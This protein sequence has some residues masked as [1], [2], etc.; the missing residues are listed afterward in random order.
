M[1][2][3]TGLY[4]SRLEN[5]S[6]CPEGGT[7]PRRQAVPSGC[8]LLDTQS[9]V[10]QPPPTLWDPHHKEGRATIPAA[11]SHSRFMLQPAVSLE[12]SSKLKRVNHGTG[13][14]WRRGWP[15]GREVF[16]PE[17]TDAQ[18]GNHKTGIWMKLETIILSKLTQ[19]ERTKP[20]MFSL[21]SCLWMPADCIMLASYAGTSEKPQGRE[22]KESTLE[23]RHCQPKHC[24]IQIS[25]NSVG[26]QWG[27]GT[28][29]ST[30]LPHGILMHVI[31]GQFSATH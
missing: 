29:V 28:C 1:C 19:E 31:N 6:Q 4:S 23:L 5:P 30:S 7:E 20:H 25:N 3:Q 14:H 18:L 2:W 22:K 21:I 13:S 12:S 26:L 9:P 8:N 24:G 10:L 27:S 17:C 11:N 15:E 16:Q